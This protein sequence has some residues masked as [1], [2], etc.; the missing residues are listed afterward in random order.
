MY[1][2]TVK[3]LEFD[4][5]LERLA[6]YT[7]NERVKE[8]ILAVEPAKTLDEARILQKQTTEAVSCSLK[9][10]SPPVSMNC[11]D[12]SASVKRVEMGGSLNCE[13]L[14]RV[15]RLLYVARRMKSYLEDFGSSDVLGEACNSIITA[16]QVEDRINSCILPDGE[17]ADDAS[18]ELAAIRRRINSLNGR[19]RENLNSMIRSTHYKKYLQDAIVSVRNDRFV[20][21]VRSEYKSEVPGIV[22]DTSS[23]GATLFIEPMSVVQSNNEIRDLRGREEREAER[24][25]YELSQ[26]VGECGH[27]LFVDYRIICD[28]DFWFCKAAFSLDYSGNEPQLNDKGIIELKKARHPFISDEKVVANDIFL[29]ESF[30]T[31]VVTGPN[32]GGKTVTLKTVGLFALMAA[33]GLHIPAA[34]GSK[35]SIFENVFADIG[36][37]QS[38]EQSLSTFSSHMVNIVS[39]IESCTPSSLVLFDELGA[40]TD[41]TEGA[42][43]AV[44]ILE[45]LRARGA[46]ILATTHYS[47]LKL[48]A[49]ATEG[50]EN[51]SCEF[52]VESLRPTYKLLIGV[53]GKSN[54]FAISKRLGLDDRVIDRAGELLSDESIKFEDVITDLEQSRIRARSESENAARLKKE[55]TELRKELENDRIKL[56]ENKKRV[57]DEAAREAKIIIMDAKDEANR[58]IRDLEKMRRQGSGAETDNKV[59]KAREEL[60]KKEDTIDKKLSSASKPRRTFVDPPKD[61]KPGTNVKIIDMNQEA[62]VLKAP[63]K[64]GLVRVQAG[65]IK[66]DVHVTNLRKTEINETKALADRYVRTTSAFTSKT[67]NVS[68]ELDVRGQNSEE[69]VDNVGKFIDDCYLASVSP[70]TIIHGK[71]TGVLRKAI[72]EYLKKQKHVKCFRNGKYG[73]GEMGVTVVE[74]Q[75]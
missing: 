68:T 14:L 64:N 10:G 9:F 39:I 19:I 13:E 25:L 30:D 74:L 59:R 18:A 22:H 44:S 46:K 20:I 11:A 16:K 60:K 1:K 36:D 66:L 6:G 65:I 26:L 4:A 35:M 27:T 53:P 63:D 62:V 55:L 42:A 71:G 5:L 40:G 43:L 52:D 61:L 58:I 54:A 2:K 24:I 47:E 37:E 75:Q 12:V 73:E 28:L 3:A 17:L 49:L 70:V 38:I 32:T 7:E 50:V 57:M 48:F 31:L 33:S 72:Q 67:K 15:S 34:D 51:A 29:G 21:P 41:P 45:F 56:K 23:S 69:A 8:R